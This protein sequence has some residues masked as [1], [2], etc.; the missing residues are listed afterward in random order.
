ME[1]EDSH[2]CL[3]CRTTI[4]GLDNYVLHRREKCQTKGE[5]SNPPP[6]QPYLNIPRTG[7]TPSGS[8]MSRS[9]LDVRSKS[10][11]SDPVLA[12][13]STHM[14]ADR[15]KHQDVGEPN[16]LVAADLS[17]EVSADDFMSHLG[18]CMVSSTPWAADMASEEPLRADD[19]F[20]L[21]ELQSCSKTSERHRQRRSIEPLQ[22]G[23]RLR[24]DV[25]ADLNSSHDSA[26]AD[27]TMDISGSEE[28]DA[29]GLPGA[30]FE[31][32]VPGTTTPAVEEVIQSCNSAEEAADSVPNADV[33]TQLPPSPSKLTFP[34]R[35]KWM[36]GLKPRDIHK[37]G[38]S[39]EVST[40]LLCGTRS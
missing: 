11:R 20:S 19:F 32:P 9:Y 36:P 3:R 25:F 38:S 1:D 30:S 35:G 2:Y 7:G 27:V 22:S 28:L 15:F 26:T 21:L 24:S 33:P 17:V 4:Q 5:S 34:S 6:A 31:S 8:L 16:P 40:T 10:S 18:L 37:S 23:D 13:S 39:V 29:S 14:E 12:S